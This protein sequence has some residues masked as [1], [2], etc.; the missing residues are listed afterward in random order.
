[1]LNPP[2]SATNEKKMTKTKDNLTLIDAAGFTT[3]D[4]PA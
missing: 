4:S 3:T 1:M 2:N